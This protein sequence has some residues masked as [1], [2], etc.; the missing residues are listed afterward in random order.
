MRSLL[1]TSIPRRLSIC[2]LFQKNISQTFI[3]SPLLTV[4]SSAT[5]FLLP[6]QSLQ[7]TGSTGADIGW[8]SITALTPDRPYFTFIFI[9]CRVANL[10]GHRVKKLSTCSRELFFHNLCI[11][12][13]TRLPTPLFSSTHIV[14]HWLFVLNL[15]YF[16]MSFI[17]FSPVHTLYYYYY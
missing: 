17:P 4:N 15:F 11:T 16:S 6:G 13:R 3:V 1:R 10:S 7:R 9:C 8:S 2:S 5:C 12:P 14:G